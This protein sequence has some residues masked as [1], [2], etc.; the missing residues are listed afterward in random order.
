MRIGIVGTSGYLGNIAKSVFEAGGHHVTEVPKSFIEPSVL[1]FDYFDF[2][3]DCGFPKRYKNKS[4]RTL[5]FRSLGYRLGETKK[6]KIPYIYL[7]SF[8]S[9]S[10]VLSNYGEM[11]LAA[12]NLVLAHAGIILRLG[13]IVNHVNPGGR[14]RELLRI[15]NKFPF[16]PVLPSN[17]CPILISSEDD[18]RKELVF[19]S[20]NLAGIPLE[21]VCKTT[22][23]NLSELLAR[24]AEPK[25]QLHLNDFLA[26]QL[27]KFV[28][29]LPVKY[30]DNLK[31][32]AFKKGG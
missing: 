7:G 23:T 8:S 14:F 26:T 21:V 6:W 11:K 31:S 2:V 3:L 12:E 1:G 19:V 16:R 29:L 32:I 27:M 15:A 9:S 22:E 17:W 28:K 24:Y 30:L 13:L 25:I 5:Y 20:E 18:F 4:T 10:Q